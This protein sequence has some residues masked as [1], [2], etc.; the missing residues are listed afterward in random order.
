MDLDLELSSLQK[1][2]KVTFCYVS[3]SAYGVLLQQLEH[4]RLMHH[5][6]QTR[7]KDASGQ[8]CHA[9]DVLRVDTLS[10]LTSGREVLRC[11]QPSAESSKSEPVWRGRGV[12][13]CSGSSR[14]G[15]EQAGRGCDG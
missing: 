14:G 8:G 11:T 15:G 6:G 3:H 12:P 9:S 4:L 5:A 10:H 7:G 2:E 1:S 13:W